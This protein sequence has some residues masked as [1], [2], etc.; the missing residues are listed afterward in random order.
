MAAIAN[1]RSKHSDSRTA[2][3]VSRAA[4]IVG[5]P[6]IPRYDGSAYGSN[7]AAQAKG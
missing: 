2:K 5:Q 6:T 1:S 3:D 4:T 7:E